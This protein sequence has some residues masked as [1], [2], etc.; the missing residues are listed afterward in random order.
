MIVESHHRARIRLVQVGNQFGWHSLV[1]FK[2][3]LVCE[4]GL[5]P[6]LHQLNR[7]LEV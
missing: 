3:L 6:A 2:P 5:D 1:T 4:Q 7:I